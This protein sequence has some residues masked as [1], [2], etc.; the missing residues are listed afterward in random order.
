MRR[1]TS[2]CPLILA[3]LLMGLAPAAGQEASESQAAV[4]EVLTRARDSG[5]LERALGERRLRAGDV[6]VVLRGEVDDPERPTAVS[7]WLEF[8]VE[9]GMREEATRANCTVGFDGVVRAVRWEVVRG[10][11]RSQGEARLNAGSLRGHASRRFNDETAGDEDWGASWDPRAVPLAL[12]VAVL[13]SIADQGLPE[14]LPLVVYSAVL[15]G[16]AP[17]EAALVVHAA[18]SEVGGWT[19][20]LEHPHPAWQ[21]E[22]ECDAEGGIRSL[23]MGGLELTPE[24]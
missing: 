18:P 15:Q 7:C 16:A 23:R 2:L 11:Q 4:S 13:A 22:V 21:V 5:A 1:T 24:Q 6:V 17:G 9:G 20:L 8:R 14:R 12:T 3:S 19:V 10:E